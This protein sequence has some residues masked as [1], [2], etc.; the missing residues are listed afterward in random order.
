MSTW[1]PIIASLIV[2]ALTACQ[3]ELYG[4]LTQRDANEMIA[5][6]SRHGIEAK[7]EQAGTEYRVTVDEKQLGAA[8]DVLRQA[9][10]PRESYKS[11]GEIFPGDGL[12]I[13][14]YE[15]RIRMMHAQNQEMG[16]TITAIDG[17]VQARVHVVMPELDLRGMP[18]TKP[19][20]SVVVHHRPGI[21]VPDLAVKI[22]TL[23][24]NGI[25]GLSPKDVAVSFFPSVEQ[26]AAPAIVRD[27]VAQTTSSASSVA[28]AVQ[29]LRASMP[30]QDQGGPSRLISILLWGIAAIMAGIGVFLVM[31]SRPKSAG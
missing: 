17:V 14:P 9:G 16:R 20:A 11:L 10:L 8:A 22:K 3:A 15:Q 28:P 23:V 5:V 13:S 30:E 4:G 18:M 29:T 12:I 27:T 7:R 1:R 19:S 6:L 26:P 21:D 25:Q 24:A 2:L 31:C